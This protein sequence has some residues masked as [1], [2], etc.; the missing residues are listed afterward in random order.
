MV[1][2]ETWESVRALEALLWGCYYPFTN[3]YLLLNFEDLQIRPHVNISSRYLRRAHENVAAVASRAIYTN[4]VLAR[5]CGRAVER[6][7]SSL[8]AV[9]CVSWPGSLIPSI[10]KALGH[11]SDGEGR[12]GQSK[13]SGLGEHDWKWSI[14]G[15]V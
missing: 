10:L 3:L 5:V 1:M 4:R 7:F 11:L 6:D 2:K 8:T 15:R 13:E 14:V 12:D 9:L